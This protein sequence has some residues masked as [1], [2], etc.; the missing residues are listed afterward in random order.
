[1]TDRDRRP[2]ATGPASNG[3]RGAWR[4]RSWLTVKFVVTIGL[5]GW[6]IGLVDWST[7]WRTVG[8]SSLWLLGLVMLL[9]LVGVTLSAFKWQQLLVVHAIRYSL[10]RL[11]GWYLV[12]SFLNHF[13]P[14]T[15][16]GDGYRIYKT[17]GNERTKGAS[18]LAIV[19]ERLTGLGALAGLGYAAAVVL[20]F[21]G[22]GTLVSSVAGFGAL[23]FAAVGVVLW[24]GSRPGVVE[25]LKQSR[26]GRYLEGLAAL[27]LDF[28][29]QP[30]KIGVVAAVSVIFHVNKLA[31]VW[32]LLYNLGTAVNPLELL[33][34][35]LIVE[36]AGLLPISLGG[37]GVVEGSFILVMAQFGVAEEVA[38]A[39]MLLRRVLMTPLYLAG[40]IL[41]LLNGREDNGGRAA[42]GPSR[43]R[44][45]PLQVK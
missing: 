3:G 37:L 40:A 34:A 38:L 19:L 43:L 6:I 33:V 5:A 31:V 4:R 26:I 12:G 44:A 23:G 2:A 30:G 22:G 8:G 9:Q 17:W 15:V 7:F 39:A 24:L 11:L 29:D 16:G 42:A 28:R 21:T 10:P 18:V 32:L 36:M 35:V 41:Y 27:A 25:W 14:S 45:E 1:M 20:H 13:L